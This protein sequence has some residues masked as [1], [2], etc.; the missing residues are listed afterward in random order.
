MDRNEMLKIAKKT[1][2]NLEKFVSS[3]EKHFDELEADDHDPET[4]QGFSVVAAVTLAK[5]FSQEGVDCSVILGKYDDSVHCWVET[6][7]EIWDL[8]LTQFSRKADS[9]SVVD[10][11]SKEGKE[12]RRGQKLDLRKLK[13]QFKDYPTEFQ[14]HNHIILNLV[15]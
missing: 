9:V 10:K 2:S 13:N 7:G 11:E 3:I 15:P 5:A 14:P 8:T 6:G 1:R 12:Y 4:L